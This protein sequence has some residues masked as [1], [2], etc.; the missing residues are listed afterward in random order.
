MLKIT[1]RTREL[2]RRTKYKDRPVELYCFDR[3]GRQLE[4]VEAVEL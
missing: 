3:K 4:K 1:E 2:L